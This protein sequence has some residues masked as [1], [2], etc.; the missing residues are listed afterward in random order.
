MSHG[1]HIPIRTCLGCGTQAPKADM[2]R[3]VLE[4][5]GRLAT[6]STQRRTGRGGYLHRRPGCWSAFAQRKGVLRSLKVAA[7]RSARAALVEQIRQT[8]TVEA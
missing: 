8:V 7:D 2:L 3:I 5:D 6:D 1:R 4:T